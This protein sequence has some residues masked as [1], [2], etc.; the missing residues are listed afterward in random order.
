M[1]FKA[2]TSTTKLKMLAALTSLKV[3]FFAH[4]SPEEAK[5]A[6]WFLMPNQAKKE[7][8]ITYVRWT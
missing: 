6:L 1:K 7:F 4:M 8:R 5:A 3:E 2:S